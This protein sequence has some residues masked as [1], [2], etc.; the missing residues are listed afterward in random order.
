MESQVK[1]LFFLQGYAKK[2]GGKMRRIVSSMAMFT[3]L[4]VYLFLAVAVAG[5]PTRYTVVFKGNKIPKNASHIISRAGGALVKA[6][7]QV[8][9]GI[10]VS[11]DPDFVDSLKGVKEL[12]S[13]GLER[14]HALPPT[15]CMAYPMSSGPQPDDFYY[16]DFQWNIRRVNADRVWAMTGGSHN[17]V[18]AVIDTGIAWNH[19]DLY[20]N[21]VY[22]TC[23]SSTDDCF[24]YPFASYEDAGWHGTHVA[25][26]I[27]AA[28]GKGAIVG[29]GP[30][31]G[32]ASYKVFEDIPGYGYGSYDMS[33]W[34]AMINAADRGFQVIN[35]SLGDLIDKSKDAATWTAWNRVA[36]YVREY[37]VVVAAAGNNSQDLNGSV[38]HIPSDLPGVVSVGA[39]GIRPGWFYPQDGTYDV[40]AYYSNFGA[41]VAMVA[42]GGDWGGGEPYTFPAGFYLVLSSFVSMPDIP[43]ELIDVGALLP[44]EDNCEE[45]ATCAP[46]YFWVGGTSL[47]AA[48]VSGVV[49]LMLDYNPDL[50]PDQVKSILN[51]TAEK[52]GDRQQFG[53]GML[54]A[55]EALNQ[56]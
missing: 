42:P 38:A 12:H 13:A 40:L 46:G 34:Q 11:D 16:P 43:Q 22:H 31:L 39:T 6:L 5:G 21:V 51:R 50:K 10:A 49:G 2:G 52:L 14:F 4:T 29:V 8:G 28:F 20:P 25:G 18:V 37:A 17:T 56:E 9:V 33:I 30:G 32:L 44:Y 36:N 3:G 15:D 27:A 26:V 24:D 55:L 23:Y 7:P 41:S 47:S 54:D 48:H 1:I 45:S 35:L 19:P 53:H